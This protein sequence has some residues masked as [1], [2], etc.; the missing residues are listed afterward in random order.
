MKIYKVENF[1]KTYG[2]KTLFKD[3]NFSIVTGDRVGLIGINGT[4]KSSLLKCIF[5]IDS[6]DSGVITHPN[7][8][9]FGYLSQDINFP[10]E[11]TVL[12]CI[13]ES[14]SKI[15]QIIK[16]YEK[17]LIELNEQPENEEKQ[18][19]LF[20]IQ[21][22]LDKENA[23]E[24]SS[25]AK[26]ILSKLG[27]TNYDK[28]IS[29][30]S[31]GQKK[32]VGLAKVLIET[33]DLL[34]LDEPT[35]HLDFETIEWL[36]KYLKNYPNSIL[37]ITHD[38]YFLDNISTRTFELTNGNLFEYVGNYSEFLK[39]RSEREANE[40]SRYLKDRQLYKKE[41]EWIRRGAK[42][43]TTKQQARIDRFE[44]LQDKV[45][46]KVE[47]NKLNIDIYSSRIGKQVFEFENISKKYDEKIILNNFNFILQN[48]SR[49]GIIGLNGVG[50]STFLNIIANKETIDS[51]T[52][53]VGQTVKIAY[54]SQLNE[55]MDL[56]LRMINYVRQGA[57]TIKNSDGNII[58]AA[59]LLEQFLF[60]LHT[61][62]TVLSKL[63]GGERRRL[64]LLRL[65]MT[66]PNV[67]ILDEP[68]NDLDTQTLTI[69]EDYLE[70]FFGAVITVSHDRYFLDKVVDELLVFKGNGNITHYIGNYSEYIESGGSLKIDEVKKEKI[71]SE[72]K[73]TTREAKRRLTY[74]ENKEWETIDAEIEKL[75]EEI[76]K[77]EED[78]IT[79]ATD[80]EKI[81]DLVKL[82][83]KL[84]KDLEYK[85]ERWEYLAEIVE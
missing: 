52:F 16:Q 14:D 27:I 36:E 19:N 59:Q 81:N 55:D 70:S 12:D 64:Y 68:T 44:I 18:N 56:T 83:L 45:N 25:S 2:E 24:A 72:N 38:R 67:L 49:L 54:Y 34:L 69:L 47:N 65:L 30:L 42:A 61:H 85:M 6:Y 78:M 37:V 43:R 17:C 46:S 31:G 50:K 29:E 71:I 62:G 58:S 33:P 13:F 73:T 84:K 10:D 79:F 40:E 3:V 15:M 48:N 32:R 39:K 80:F 77:V 26:T 60:P 9:T 21:E 23:W 20:K 7:D 63:S 51:G 76:N 22:L 5:G 82:Q 28:K 41:L 11:L 8:Y 57:E 74:K 4:G 35:N 53:K 1:K 66:Q 75:E